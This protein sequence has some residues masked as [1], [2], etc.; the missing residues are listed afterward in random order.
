MIFLPSESED[1]SERNQR[2]RDSKRC[3]HLYDVVIAG[4]YIALYCIVLY[5]VVL[6]PKH[7][8]GGE[9]KEV[10]ERYSPIYLPTL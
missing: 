9:E 7:K 3:I 2:I 6:L 4:L 5:F 10:V 1:L 8:L